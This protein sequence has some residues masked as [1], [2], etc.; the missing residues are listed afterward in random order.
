MSKDKKFKLLLIN[1]VQRQRLGLRMRI[2]TTYPPIAL[3]IVAALTPEHWD[4]KLID[5]NFDEFVFEEA[6]L[7]AFTSFT[8]SAPRVYEIAA[9]YRQ[10]NIKTVY[11]GVHATVCTD[12][13]INYVDVVVRGE[14]ESVW[15]KVLSDFENN[16]LKQIYEGERCDPVKIPMPRYDLY[17]KK[18]LFHGVTASRGCPMNCDFCSVSVF[19]GTKQRF[20]D[21]DDI[22]DEIEILPTKFFVFLDDNIIGYSQKGK[23][24]AIE[25]FKGMVKRGIKKYWIAQ[26]SLHVADE[27]EVLKWA[28]KSGCKILFIGIEAEVS[29]GLKDVHKNLNL[30]IGVENYKKSFKKIHK[31]G[32]GVLG[33]FIFGLDSDTPKML[34]DRGNFIKKSSVDTY[35]TTILTPLPGT[36]LYKK[37]KE[38]RRLIKTNYPDDW[39]YYDMRE[40]VFKLNKMRSDE[41]I[42][43]M[44]DVWHKIYNRRAARWKFIRTLFNTR[45]LLTAIWTYG[46][47][48]NYYTFSFEEEILA[49]NPKYYKW[50]KKYTKRKSTKKQSS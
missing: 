21:I 41:F 19:S 20:R 35:Q 37:F 13:A 11:G 33:A 44:Y 6:D 10:H 7:V 43:V 4:V 36:P 15:A 16:D 12:E 30:K 17:N 48:Y 23:E 18:Y 26:A 47:I 3:G 40:H 34:Y 31:Y 28:A 45:N 24:R 39:D 32:I 2:A 14:A 50:L 38:E 9:I 42:D 22:L 1:P 46:S 25:I 5:E 29:S 49:K 8:V 27:P